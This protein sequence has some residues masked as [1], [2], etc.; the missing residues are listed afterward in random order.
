[1]ASYNTGARAYLGTRTEFR[2]KCSGASCKVLVRQQARSRIEQYRYPFTYSVN[3]P[4]F[5]GPPMGSTFSTGRKALIVCIG[6]VRLSQ[7]KYGL[8]F[9]KAPRVGLSGYGRIPWLRKS[10]IISYHSRSF[11]RGEFYT[12]PTDWVDGKR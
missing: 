9:T 12:S 1:M 5:N 8:E 6:L 3:L 10:R 2:L 11:Q 7:V 4:A